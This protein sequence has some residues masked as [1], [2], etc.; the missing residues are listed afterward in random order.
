MEI[1]GVR[2]GISNMGQIVKDFE[3]FARYLGYDVVGSV[4]TRESFVLFCFVF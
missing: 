4:D 3:Y 2:V 1:I